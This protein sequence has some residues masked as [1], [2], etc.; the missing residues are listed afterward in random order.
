MCIK[1]LGI[2][3]AG[4]VSHR[5]QARRKECN[6]QDPIDTG[7][8]RCFR[9]PMP[10]HRLVKRVASLHCP[11]ERKMFTLSGLNILRYVYV[12]LSQKYI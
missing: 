1:G 6:L 2:Q 10:V 11:A 3:P 8:H 9:I 4:R 12:V 7:T 5:S